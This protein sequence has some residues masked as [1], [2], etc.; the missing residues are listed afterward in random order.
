MANAWVEVM[1]KF[2]GETDPIGEAWFVDSARVP[3]AAVMP[4]GV[5]AG[6]TLQLFGYHHLAGEEVVVMAA[7]LNLGTALVN[8]L[9]VINVGPIEHPLWTRD[10]LDTYEAQTLAG[11]TWDNMGVELLDAPYEILKLPIVAGYPM[12]SRGQLLR[13]IAPADTGAQTGPALGMTRRTS[14]FSALL[15]RTQDIY[16]GTTFGQMYPVEFR[17]PGGQRYPASQ[18]FSGVHWGTLQDD[19]SF[20]SMLCWETTGPLP[21]TILTAGAFIQTQDR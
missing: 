2:F 12:T 19:Y 4:G 10:Y 18:L 8:E 9:G 13:P 20:D 1:T 21:A 14:Q 11:E 3:Y 16:F 5:I 6:G 7:G 17:R 15:H